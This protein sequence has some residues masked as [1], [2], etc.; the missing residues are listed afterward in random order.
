MVDVPGSEKVFDSFGSGV[1]LDTPVEARKDM[2]C[3]EEEEKK[4][5]QLEEIF[6][7]SKQR[8]LVL[9][10]AAGRTGSCLSDRFL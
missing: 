10:V 9:Q 6:G 8:E 1:H 7:N 5:H 2:E 4:P 3:K